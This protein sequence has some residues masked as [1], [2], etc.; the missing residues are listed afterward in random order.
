MEPGRGARVEFKL[1]G[2]L[3]VEVDGRVVAISGQRQRSLL[4]LL[5]LHANTPVTRDR[6]IDASTRPWL[7]G[8]PWL[9]ACAVM[10][11]DGGRR[12]GRNQRPNDE[13]T[14]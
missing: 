11:R 6:L 7:W 12:R 10:A 13:R 14:V 8:W 4:G 9:W 5:L 3:E 1:L 2:P